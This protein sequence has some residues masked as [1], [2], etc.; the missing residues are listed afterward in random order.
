M[1]IIPC[2]ARAVNL[3]LGGLRLRGNEQGLSPLLLGRVVVSIHHLNGRGADN[4]IV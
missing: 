1:P 3:L 2:E 4:Q